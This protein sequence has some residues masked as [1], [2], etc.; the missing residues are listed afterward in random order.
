M[1]ICPIKREGNAYRD[2]QLSLGELPSASA[3]REAISNNVFDNVSAFVPNSTFAILSENELADVEKIKNAVLLTLRLMDRDKLDVAISDRGLVNRI[4]DTA[5]ECASFN[6]FEYK[7]QTKKYT[8]SAIRRAILYILLGVKQGDLEKMPE[9][10]VLLGASEKGREYLSSIR[11]NE[12]AIR[13]IT[14][15][16]DAEGNRQFEISKKAD[17]L[18]TMCFENK[19]ESGFYIKKSPVIV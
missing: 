4:L 18:Y 17:A 1:Q 3:I 9:Y 12:S 2:T 5:H 11:K 6:E 19:K 13:I 14:K 15:P 8:A 10:T 16:A 7:L